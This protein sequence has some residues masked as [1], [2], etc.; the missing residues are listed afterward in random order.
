MTPTSQRTFKR[1][2]HTSYFL[3]C[4]GALP[5]SAEGHDS[6]RYVFP[7][8]TSPFDYGAECGIESQ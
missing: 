1:N 7:G 8:P 3:R 4:L 2:A 5:A 6:N